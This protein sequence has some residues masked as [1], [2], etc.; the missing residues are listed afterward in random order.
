VLA[1]MFVSYVVATRAA[2]Q[3]SRKAVLMSIA[4]LHALVLFAPP[5]LSTDISATGVWP[6]GRADRRRLRAFGGDCVGVI[7]EAAI[8]ERSLL[9][10]SGC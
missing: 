4:A 8:A 9:M 7:D 10:E 3:L 2:D 1:L 5:L 6:H